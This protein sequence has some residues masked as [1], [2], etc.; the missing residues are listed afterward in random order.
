M[1]AGG[2]GPVIGGQ[3]AQLQGSALELALEF[4]DDEVRHLE[5]LRAALG[6]AAL[7]CPEIDIGYSFN[8]FINLTLTALQ[9]PNPYAP[10]SA[11]Y[12]F[13]NLYIAG[14]ILSDP[15]VFAYN[16]A[17]TLISNKTILGS[18]AGILAVEGYHAGAIRQN[19][20]T[21]SLSFETNIY[22]IVSTCESISFF[23]WNSSL[24]RPYGLANLG[25]TQW[26][27]LSSISRMKRAC[28]FHI[29]SLHLF[30]KLCTTSMGRICECRLAFQNGLWDVVGRTKAYTASI[31]SK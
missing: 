26:F 29:R 20:A 22:T 27:Q 17:S 2:G 16:G 28:A 23:A 3:K 24:L 25:N 30:E 13:P 18:A 4:A 7:P 21:V 19:L 14:F 12:S 10:F 5:F 6:S 31:R 11:Y 9:N 8:N 15:E 1:H